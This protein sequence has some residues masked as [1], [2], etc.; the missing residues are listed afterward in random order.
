MKKNFIP[1]G[2]EVKTLSTT[3]KKAVAHRVG[4]CANCGWVHSE[5]RRI[6]TY[7]GNAV[8]KAICVKCIKEQPV[9]VLCDLCGNK[10]CD[11]LYPVSIIRKVMDQGQSCNLFVHLCSECRQIE[12]K[13]VLNRMS[14]PDVCDTC[15][16]RFVCFTEKT[17]N[18]QPSSEQTQGT[19]GGKKT[20]LHKRIRLDRLT[21]LDW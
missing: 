16:D 5:I 21:N 19:L 8:I 2:W 9:H 6:R 1:R 14:M 3:G 15:K 7:D 12:H 10:K 17:S 18:Y 13:E 20:W 11:N 4:Y